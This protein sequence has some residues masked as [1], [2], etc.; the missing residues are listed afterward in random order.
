MLFNFGLE[1]K[2][3]NIFMMPLYIFHKHTFYYVIIQGKTE[4]G[5][6]NFY[7]NLLYLK[8]ISYQF[9]FQGFFF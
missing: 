3:D 1:Q 8:L 7:Y 9:N 4:E 6:K 2:T 5:Q